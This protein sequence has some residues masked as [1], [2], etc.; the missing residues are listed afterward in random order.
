MV[1][2]DEEAV[3]RNDPFSAVDGMPEHRACTDEGT[4]LFGAIRAVA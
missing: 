4:V 2:N 1:D 3:G